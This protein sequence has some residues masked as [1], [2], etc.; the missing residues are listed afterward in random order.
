[1]STNGIVTLCRMKMSNPLTPRIYTVL[2]EN[3]VLN[4]HDIFHEHNPSIK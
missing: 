3:F 4:L 2:K 1:M